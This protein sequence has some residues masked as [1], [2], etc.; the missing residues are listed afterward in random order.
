MSQGTISVIFISGDSS[1]QE[2]RNAIVKADCINS[3][4]DFQRG[5][6]AAEASRL[7]GVPIEGMSAHVVSV[8]F[9]AQARTV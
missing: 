7:T 9:D 2:W 3:C 4:G 6:I 5:V 1:G 8:E